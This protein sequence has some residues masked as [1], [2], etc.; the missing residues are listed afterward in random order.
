M[1]REREIRR[2]ARARARAIAKG[3]RG[4]GA[5]AQRKGKK[6][7]ELSRD[8][9][10]VLVLVLVLVLAHELVLV[11]VHE[12]V[13]VLVY[14]FVHVLVLALEPST[15]W[16]PLDDSLISC[17][18]SAPLAPWPLGDGPC[19]SP[20]P[21]PT[22]LLNSLTIRGCVSPLPYAIEPPEEIARQFVCGE[23][24]KLP[25]SGKKITRF[26]TVFIF[27]KYGSSRSMN[28]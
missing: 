2:R 20:L 28:P 15:T 11:L 17:P 6:R 10:V 24:Q 21:L 12:L 16:P 9:Q 14:V 8:C 5:K 25:P 4:Q 23:F 26:L 1:G 27:Q 13:L 7:V 3:P 19:S 22:P 18:S